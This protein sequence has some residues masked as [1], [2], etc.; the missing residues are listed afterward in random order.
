[1]ALPE[2]QAEIAPA[3]VHYPADQLPRIQM[4]GADVCLIIG[5]AYGHRSPVAAYSP[6]LYLECQLTEGATLTLPDGHTELGVYVVS[7]DLRIEHMTYATGVLAVARNGAT[8]TLE[9]LQD[10]RVM[11]LGG[12]PVGERLLWWNFV[13]SGSERIER[14]KEDWRQMRFDPVPGDAEFIPLPPR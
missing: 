6:M 3:F 12:D 11:V 14:A 2:A 8:L 9:A 4:D 7:G 10:S 13:A 1:M 5:E